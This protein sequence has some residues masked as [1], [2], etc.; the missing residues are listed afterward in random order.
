MTPKAESVAVWTPP[1][2]PELSDESLATIPPLLDK[3]LGSRAPV[4]LDGLLLFDAAH[5][6][7]APH[8]YL[9]F[10]ATHDD[11]RGNGIAEQ[12]LADNLTRIDAEHMPAYLESSNPKNLTRYGRLGF[13]P[14]DEFALPDGGPTVTTMWRPAR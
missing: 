11:H 8:Y 9:G 1:N 13:V 2:V 4:V 6:H 3:L 12:L 7:D 14:R 10:V 5:P